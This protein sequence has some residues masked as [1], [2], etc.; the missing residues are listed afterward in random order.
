MN[1]QEKKVDI[2]PFIY[3]MIMI[4]VFGVCILQ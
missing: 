2:S 1:T 4:I 3:V